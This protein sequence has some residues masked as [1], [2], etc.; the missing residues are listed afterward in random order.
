MRGSGLATLLLLSACTFRVAGDGGDDGG[1]VDGAV[2]DGAVRDGRIDGGLIVDGAIDGGTPDALLPDA[3]PP[4]A[5]PPDASPPDAS[6][7]DASPPDA[8]PPDAS[9]PDAAPT[10]RVTANQIALWTFSEASGDVAHDTSGLAPALDLVAPDAG[11]LAWGGGT[12]TLTSNT[13]VSLPVDGL[14]NRASVAIRTSGQGTLEA[15]VDA[16]SVAQGG[17]PNPA[18]PARVFTISRNTGARNLALG[19]LGDAWVGQVRTMHP[20][21]NTTGNPMLSAGAGSVT[22]APTHLVITFDGATRNLY[23]DGVL[24]AS[25]ARGGLLTR[26]DQYLRITL[27]AETM[28]ATPV[29]PWLGSYDM[30]ALFD[31]ALSADEVA[32]NFAAG[33][34]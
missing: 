13:R 18:H 22:L 24:V 16:A 2:A 12:M 7:P 21:V 34:E 10:A 32:T 26:W 30:I 1:I 3:S 15:W 33:P 25:D 19:Q 9:P 17:T 14:K 5:S 6:P 11:L 4:D 23:L 31:R 27:G 8:S 20:E 29:N 28:G